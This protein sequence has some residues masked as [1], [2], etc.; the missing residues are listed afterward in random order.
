MSKDKIKEELK[1]VVCEAVQDAFIT[2]I[3]EAASK[4]DV[5]EE[6]E[7]EDKDSEEESEEE[8][9]DDEE[10]EDDESEEDDSVNES[11]EVSATSA[12]NISR[13]TV[14]TIKHLSR[15]AKTGKYDHFVVKQKGEEEVEYAVS[16]GRL[17][18]L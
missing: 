13:L 4:K 11:I 5:R 9:E 17:V 2:A 12:G 3:N 16:N 15:L 10:E 7:K 8:S 6:D 1:A 14:P 18:T